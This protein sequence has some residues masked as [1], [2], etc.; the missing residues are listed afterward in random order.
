LLGLVILGCMGR[1]A[2]GENVQYSG[3]SSAVNQFGAELYGQLAKQDGNLFCSPL[4]VYSVLAMV[5]EGARGETATELSKVLHRDEAGG[6][7]VG[8]FLGEVQKPDENFELH[9]ANAV[10]AQDGFSYLPAFKQVLADEY[11]SDFFNVDFFDSAKASQRIN[12]WVSEQTSGKITDLFPPGALPQDAKLVLTNAIYFHADWQSQFAGDLSSPGE[13][14][15]A[16]KQDAKECTFMH[17][18][19]TYPFMAGEQFD[20]LELPYK[21]EQVGMVILLPKATDGLKDLEA[22]FSAKLLQ[23][24]TAGLQPKFVSAMIP[25]FNFARE[26][27]LPKVLEAMGIQRAFEASVADFSG[28][29]GKRDLFLSDVRHK[30][31]VAVDEEGTTAAAATGGVMRPTAVPMPTL[32]FNA[33]HPFMF[34][35]LD[36]R[37]GAVLFVGRVCDPVT[38]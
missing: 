2:R 29:D 35:I 23:D 1:F 34:V 15:L 10:W 38:K 27:S 24:V 31:F 14:H 8:K 32:E 21:G 18:K 25:K 7:D 28:I 11:K 12:D 16:G 6:E 5:E 36:H 17:Q 9:T 30:A 13:F 3:A 37:S 22:N 33:D 26:A 19:R 4:S 20:A